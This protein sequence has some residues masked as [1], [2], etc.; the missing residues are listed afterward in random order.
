MINGQIAPPRPC[1]FTPQMWT[2]FELV[3]EGVF[4]CDTSGRL[5]EVNTFAC[6]MLGYPRSELLKLTLWDLLTPQARPLSLAELKVGQPVF[7][8]QHLRGKDGRLLS[9]EISAQ[10]IDDD[11]LIAFVRDI[12]ERKQAE[13]ALRQSEEH[14]AKTFQASPVAMSISRQEDGQ[15]IDINDGFLDLFGYDREDVIG[16]TAL[17]L[18]LY[19]QPDERVELIRQLRE[20]GAL[21][22]YEQTIVVKSGEPRE[23][24]ISAE[25]IEM[26]GEDHLL[27]IFVDI[28]PRKQI[29][30][31]LREIVDNMAVAQRIS[32]FGSWEVKF[33]TDLQPVEPH[34]WSDECYRIFG[35]EP[36]AVEMTTELF[37]SLIHP[38]DRQVM[39]QRVSQAIEEYVF[40]PYEHR[41]ILPDGTVRTVWEQ[42][43]VVLD[44]TGSRPIKLVGTVHDIT[45]RKQAEAALQANKKRLRLAIEAAELGIYEQAVSLDGNTYY[46]ERWAAILG[47]D[48]EELPAP[49]DRYEWVIKQVHP[50]DLATL[51]AAY[52]E[53]VVG[54]AST[55]STEIRMK[56]KSGEWIWIKNYGK[57]A[58]RNEFGQITRI[59]GVIQDITEAKQLETQLRQAQRMESVGRLAGGVAHDFNNLL[60]IIQGYAELMEDRLNLDGLLRQSLTQIQQAAHSAAGLTRQLLAFSRQQMLAPAVL[61]LNHLVGNLQKML[62]RLIGEDIMLEIDLTEAVHPV[63]ADPGQLEQVLLNLAVNARDAMPTGGRLII[64][65]A[66]VELD[67]VY[68]SRDLEAPLGPAVMLAVTDTGCG[69]DQSTQAK[70]FDP[71]FTTKA[72]GQG[73]GLGLATVYGIVKQSGGDIHVYSEPGQGT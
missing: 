47:Y 9:V 42:A 63:L 37:V 54:R 6:Q 46:S 72:L 12:S 39:Q 10:R 31:T 64:E 15:L 52:R 3:G 58:E 53:F 14:F 40:H 48:L 20:Q 62:T 24:L 19:P 16:R 57:V 30:A 17:E 59:L 34:L 7:M 28:T 50:D 4:L 35:L 60:T 38:D 18:G 66:N 33:T 21:Y 56:H 8:E 43:S 11:H 71:F 23:T 5:C 26:N 49:T 29:E 41:I 1:I 55:F 65:M 27:A 51:A 2:V 68:L 22:N 67:Q 36:G 13:A 44:E 45:E 70:I 25:V 73:T 69:M 32:H 61:D